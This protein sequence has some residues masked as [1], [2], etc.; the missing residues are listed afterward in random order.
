MDC[1]ED[2]GAKRVNTII[3]ME[4]ATTQKQFEHLHKMIDAKHASASKVYV[5]STALKNILYDHSQF[6]GITDDFAGQ[7]IIRHGTV[8]ASQEAQYCYEKYRDLEGFVP[9]EEEDVK[10][11]EELI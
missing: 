3:E 1:W 4:C 6:C 7:L 8:V 10:I 11:S 2:K 9:K 5:D